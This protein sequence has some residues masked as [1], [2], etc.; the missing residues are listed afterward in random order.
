M[1]TDKIEWSKEKELTSYIY[2]KWL[3]LTVPHSIPEMFHMEGSRSK[4]FGFF[5]Q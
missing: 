2:L 1:K 4:M 3:P 5:F